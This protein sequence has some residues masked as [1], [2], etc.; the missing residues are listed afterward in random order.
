MAVKL[1]FLDRS[2]YFLEIAPQLS[3]RGW[4]TTFQ[5]LFSEDLVVLGIEPGTSV[6]CSQEL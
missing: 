4:C 2:C 6:I 1:T 5:T 3:S